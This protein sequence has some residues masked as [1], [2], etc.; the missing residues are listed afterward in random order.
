M[1][2]DSTG[3]S[4]GTAGTGAETCQRC[5]ACSQV[6]TASGMLMGSGAWRGAG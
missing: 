4:R 6:S 1:A 2:P 3:H 5:G